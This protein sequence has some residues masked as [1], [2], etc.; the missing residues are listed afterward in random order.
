[1]SAGISLA[2]ALAGALGGVSVLTGTYDGPPPRAGFPY[3]VIDTGEEADWSHK[4]GSGRDV[5]TKRTLGGGSGHIVVSH[6]SSVFPP[7]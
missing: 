2:E 1:M 6:V 5:R 7:G 3:A 4:S